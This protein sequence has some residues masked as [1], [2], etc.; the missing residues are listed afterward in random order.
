MWYVT[1]DAI[2]VKEIGKICAAVGRDMWNDA[3]C[4]SLQEANELADIIRDLAP[5]A[6]IEVTK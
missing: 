5:L 2:S 4:D 6:L 1:I 3:G